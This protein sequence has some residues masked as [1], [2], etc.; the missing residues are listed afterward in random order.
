MAGKT[1]KWTKERVIQESKKY[2][3]RGA[4]EKANGSAYGIA[5]ANGG[6]G[7]LPWLKPIRRRWTREAVFE[8]A[9]TPNSLNIY[10]KA[11]MNGWLTEMPWLES[12]Y[13]SLG[14]RTCSGLYLTNRETGFNTRQ[15]Q[16]GTQDGAQNR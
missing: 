12:S 9:K 1:I 4:F 8:E 6:L 16:G 13:D 11:K 15:T 10:E 14:L 2:S 3:S 7:E 5:L